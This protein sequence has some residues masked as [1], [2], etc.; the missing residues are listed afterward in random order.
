MELDNGGV[1]SAIMNYLNPHTGFG[2]WGNEHL[3]IFGTLGFIE[4]VDAGSKTRLVVGAEDRGALETE[5]EKGNN[6]FFDRMINQILEKGEPF[7]SIEDELHPTRV[8]ILAKESALSKKGI[9]I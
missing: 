2:N 8:V 9:S 4:A 6:S 1:A 7:F 5:M 3:R